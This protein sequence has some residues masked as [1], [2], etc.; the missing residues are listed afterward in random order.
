[1]LKRFIFAMLLGVMFLG[2]FFYKIR[3]NE[4]ITIKER[5][6]AAEMANVKYQERLLDIFFVG[7]ISDAKLIAELHALKSFAVSESNFLFDSLKHDFLSFLSEKGDYAQ[8]RFLDKRGYEKLRVDVINGQPKLIPK[9][10][11]QDKSERYYFIETRKLEPGQVYLSPLDLNVEHHKIEL[12]FKPMLRI[13]V[14]I[15]DQQSEFRGALVVNYLASTMLKVFKKAGSNS[16][17]D[18]SLLNNEGFLA[19]E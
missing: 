4:I 3:E 14:P 11:L 2:L 6:A 8:I 10:Q 19:C 1:M 16:L 5:I 18:S 12:P 9:K 15:F 13:G 17:G 7:H